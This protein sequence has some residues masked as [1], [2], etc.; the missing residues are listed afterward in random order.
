MQFVI[1]EPAAPRIENITMGG[2]K[3][4]NEGAG[5]VI[6]TG[7]F[8]YDPSGSPLKST[9]QLNVDWS[10]WENHTFFNSAQAKVQTSLNQIINQYPFD[11]TKSEYVAF[12]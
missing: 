9:Q 5:D 12:I 11:G 4:K 6:N 2:D 3:E 10:K 7:S 1:L 8:R